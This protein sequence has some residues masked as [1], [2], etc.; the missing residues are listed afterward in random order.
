MSN[1][2]ICAVSGNMTRDLEV[3]NTTN[4]TPVA[5][6]AV[7]INRSRKDDTAEGG[8]REETTF[9]DI[10]IWGAYAELCARK[11]KKGDSI[12]VNGRLEQQNW[13][14]DSGEKRSKI[15][16]IADQIDS[17]GFFRSKT[18]D[19]APSAVNTEAPAPAVAAAPAPANDDI[20]F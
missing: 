7:A 1:I 15:V 17:E 19:N 14:S 6:T 10:T 3:R 16:L 5:N 11:L 9:L 8:Y 2:N 13:E 12:T 18:E 20:P 4:G